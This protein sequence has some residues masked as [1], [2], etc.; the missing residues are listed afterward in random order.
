MKRNKHLV[1]ICAALIMVFVM[2]SCSSNKKNESFNTSY[3]PQSEAREYYD[4]EFSDS[5]VIRAGRNKSSGIVEADGFFDEDYIMSNAVAPTD[6]GGGA[7]IMEI[8][9]SDRKVILNG[10]IDMQANDYNET[11]AQLRNITLAAGGFIESS[12]SYVYTNDG[13]RDYKRGNFTFRVPFETYEAV[14]LEMEATGH[15]LST[16]DSSQ[17]A[18]TEF[19]D[20]ESRVKSLRAQE[21]SVLNMIERAEKI[22]DLLQLEKRLSDIRTD[23]ELYQSRL[24]TI[25]RQASFS[26]IKVSLEEVQVF[27][28]IRL[29]PETAWERIQNSF[30]N[31]VNNI[32]SFFE[33]AVVYLVGAVLPFL[34]FC[35]LALVAWLIIRRANRKYLKKKKNKAAA[36]NTTIEIASTSKEEGKK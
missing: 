36:E 14:K 1:I 24:N 2:V 27:E 9:Q 33:N 3:A 13:K 5:N 20:T 15:V 7:D 6:T 30:I 32:I 11:A 34:L 4:Y 18:T 25:D 12:S 22:E 8:K 35:L 16:S 21:T 26:T 29:E 23:I 19:F 10:Y 31:S 28:T 17:D